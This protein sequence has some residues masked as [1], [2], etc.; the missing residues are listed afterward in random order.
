MNR[1]IK[2]RAWAKDAKVM[3][4]VWH[5]TDDEGGVYELM[6][7]TGLKDSTGREIYEGDFLRHGRDVRLGL[8][9][10]EPEWARFSVTLAPNAL[11]EQ[12]SGVLGE[13]NNMA[14]IQVVG[15]YYENPE[16]SEPKS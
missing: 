13:T 1:E 15:N 4:P 8:V 16:L 11:G 12:T 6:Q 3:H 14:E 5:R 2:F 10:Y 9:E 7:Y